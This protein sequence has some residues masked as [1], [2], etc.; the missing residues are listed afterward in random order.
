[1]RPKGLKPLATQQQNVAGR[2]PFKRIVKHGHPQNEN[3]HGYDAFC[4]QGRRVLAE[5]MKPQGF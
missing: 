3:V 5:A 1:M 2:N 4:R